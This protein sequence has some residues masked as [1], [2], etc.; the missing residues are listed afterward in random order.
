MRNFAEQHWGISMSAIKA[1]PAP[2]NGQ[3]HGTET[4]PRCC[5]PAAHKP[6]H[7]LGT[8][9]PLRPWWSGYPGAGLAALGAVRRGSRSS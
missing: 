2:R 9:Y 7:P 1:D 4:T 5:R 3:A 8:G 6:T